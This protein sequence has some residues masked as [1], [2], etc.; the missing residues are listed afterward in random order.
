MNKSLKY[1]LGILLVVFLTG[2]APWQYIDMN[3]SK[4]SSGPFES[5]LP[6]GWM[7]FNSPNHILMVTKDGFLLQAISIT[8]SKTNQELPYTKKKIKEDMLL[9]EISSLV[10][11][12][13]SL[14]QSYK[15]LKILM[16]KPVKVGG[17]DA[18]EIE[19]TFNNDDFVKYHVLTYGFLLKKQFYELE[20]A[21]TEQHYYKHDLKD[22]EEFVGS[23]NVRVK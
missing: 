7:K 4:W 1:S 23:F 10:V 19:F 13:M 22:F 6:N 3:N 8:K 21:A 17:V 12:E 11:D 18:F 9:E 5:V 2:C 14:D 15:N 16:N 20:Y